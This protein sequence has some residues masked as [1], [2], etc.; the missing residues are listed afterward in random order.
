[1]GTCPRRVTNQWCADVFLTIDFSEK[2][3]P[4]FV[5]FANFYGIN[6]PTT[7]NLSYQLDVIEGRK[8]KNVHTLL[9]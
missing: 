9:L 2:K 5:V 3:K 6:T 1:M 7:A 4:W 8:E